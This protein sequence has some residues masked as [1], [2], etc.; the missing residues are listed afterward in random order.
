M[1]KPES[2]YRLLEIW[3]DDKSVP[4]EERAM[5]Y[6]RYHLRERAGLLCDDWYF[7]E[8]VRHIVAYPMMGYVWFK[9]HQVMMPIALPDS[10]S[11]LV[12]TMADGD[13]MN[14]DGAYDVEICV[15][16]EENN[17]ESDW[18][19]GGAVMSNVN[20]LA[21]MSVLDEYRR[22]VQLAGGVGYGNV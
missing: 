21:V 19:L 7:N 4:L 3:R 20:W 17:R 8:L 15:Y 11:N 12:V 13:E 10:D 5:E 6:I 1:S 22:H 18:C 16:L 14:S 9:R 2:L